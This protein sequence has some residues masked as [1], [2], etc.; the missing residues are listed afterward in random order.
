MQANPQGLPAAWW[1]ILIPLFVIGFYFLIREIR[2][3]NR[4]AREDAMRDLAPKHEE[5]TEAQRR[6]VRG[7]KK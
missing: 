1:Y 2:K 6:W 7:L 5:I 4:E 3:V